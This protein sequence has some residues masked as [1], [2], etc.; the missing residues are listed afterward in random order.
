M[1]RDI[2]IALLT[3]AI[4]ATGFLVKRY[5]QKDRI[6]EAITRKDALLALLDK[7]KAKA[8]SPISACSKFARP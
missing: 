6:T 2:V 3:A 4:T 1:L 7:M 8:G 5:L